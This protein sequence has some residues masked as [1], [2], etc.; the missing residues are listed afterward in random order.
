MMP[1]HIWEG[2]RG[3]WM[4]PKKAM[5]IFTYQKRNWFNENFKRD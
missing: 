2:E 1:N 5:D 3:G 4:N